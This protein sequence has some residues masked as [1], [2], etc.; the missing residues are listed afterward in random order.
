MKHSILFAPMIG[1]LFFVV[2]CEEDEYAELKIP[3]YINPADLGKNIQIFVAQKPFV[4]TDF[5]HTGAYAFNAY[6]AGTPM[7]I[8]GNILVRNR[9]FKV[10][11]FSNYYNQMM[12]YYW[13]ADFA[14][15]FVAENLSLE[16][17]DLITVYK[18]Q[19][20]FGNADAATSETESSIIV[21]VQNG[22]HNTLSQNSHINSGIPAKGYIILTD[23]FIYNGQNLYLLGSTADVHDQVEEEDEDN[24][25]DTA[26][27]GNI[28]VH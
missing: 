25:T 8:F 5:N 21:S 15:G 9:F 23:T 17:G 7:F 22:V 26:I 16:I 20:N 10:A 28:D 4:S 12:D 27:V 11:K 13:N 6:S 24:N 3:E 14:P 19:A 1:L 2:C 18:V